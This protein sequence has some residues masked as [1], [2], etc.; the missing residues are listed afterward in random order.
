MR[1]TFCVA[2][3]NRLEIVTADRAMAASGEMPGVDVRLLDRA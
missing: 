3:R 2:Y 1:L